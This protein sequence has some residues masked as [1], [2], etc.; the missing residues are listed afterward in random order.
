MS[1]DAGATVH[2]GGL[3]LGGTAVTSTAAEINIIDGGTSATSTTIAGADRVV[4][5]DNGTMKQVAFSDIK[6]YISSNTYPFVLAEL[7]AQQNTQVDQSLVSESPIGLNTTELV[8]IG[9]IFTINASDYIQTSEAGYYEVSV[10]GTWFKDAVNTKYLMFQVQKSSDGSSWSDVPGGKF[11]AIGTNSNHNYATAF[12]TTA[13]Q[14]SADDMIR[15]T[16]VQNSVTNNDY[17]FYLVSTGYD[18]GSSSSNP[19][20]TT[21]MM[22]KIGE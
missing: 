15:V 4:L 5:N 21:I 6:T 10:N 17:T 16:V 3:N 8:K 12:G 1:Q 11:I 14:L 9:S 22:K 13:V 20:D 7:D 19:G 18:G 2:A